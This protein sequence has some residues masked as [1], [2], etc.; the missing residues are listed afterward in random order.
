MRFYLFFGG[1]MIVDSDK[2]EI[3]DYWELAFLEICFI[4][5]PSN[6]YQT[7]KKEV[8][9]LKKKIFLNIPIPISAAFI[10]MNKNI[11]NR[12]RKSTNLPSLLVYFVKKRTVERITGEANENTS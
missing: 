8:F 1:E 2:S 9:T 11:S 6:L 5:R 7:G 12:L 3:F 4:I 10:K